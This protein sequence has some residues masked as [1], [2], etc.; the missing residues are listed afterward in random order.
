MLAQQ[1]GASCG[2]EIML[3]GLDRDVHEMNMLE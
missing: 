2:A 3:M 1:F